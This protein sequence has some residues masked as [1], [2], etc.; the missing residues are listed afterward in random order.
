M[1][2]STGVLYIASG[3]KYIR[4]AMQSAKS[5]R[6]FCPGLATH[7][8]ADWD[9][10]G[11]DFAASPGPFTS[12]GLID[13]PHYRSKVDYLARTPFERTLYLDTDTLLTADIREMFQVLDRFDIALSHAHLRNTPV[14]T[15]TWRVALPPAFPQFNGG[16]ILFAAKPAVLA[17]LEQWRRSFREAG[18]REDQVTL[19]E[20]LWLSDLRIAT[21]PP[22]Y[23]TR[24]YKYHVMWRKEE[25][26][27]RIFHLRRL[28]EGRL[29]FV[30][31]WARSCGRSLVR[32]GIDPR[33]WPIVGSLARKGQ[34]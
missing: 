28:H 27:A 34:P 29:W 8:F 14:R 33:K 18:F 32:A 9:R 11:F 31:K 22:E 6:R 3:A 5:V 21:L 19:R 23:N 24:F 2:D 25:A 1:T 20:L 7:L 17:F 26:R 12:V 10:H 4:A 13:D 16:V 30:R 15:A